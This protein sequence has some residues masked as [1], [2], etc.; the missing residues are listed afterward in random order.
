MQP[1][2][3]FEGVGGERMRQAGFTIVQDTTGWATLG[4]FTALKNV[5]RLWR[6]MQ[7]L[8]RRVVADPPDGIV[9]LDFGAFHVR[10]ALALRQAGYTGPLLYGFPPSAWLDRPKVARCV[11]ELS[12]PLVAFGHQRDFYASLGLP[13]R[14]FGHPLASTILPRLPHERSAHGRFV[15]LPG[16]REQEICQHLPRMLAAIAL[17]KEQLPQAECVV[18]A[19][20][21]RLERVFR[22]RLPAGVAVERDARTWL[23]WADVACVASGTAVL[24]AALLE[25]PTVAIYALSRLNAWIARRMYRGKYVTLPNLVLDQAVVP[26]LLQDAATPQAIAEQLLGLREDPQAQLQGLHA[27]RSALGGRGALRA[28]AEYAL[29]LFAPTGA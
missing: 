11:A 20:D 26:E 4:P 22:E 29:Q 13:V 28:W 10:F 3:S 21:S 5:P 9:L 1:G 24:E 18:V 7:R 6:V 27:L 17:L 14:Y 8:V 23:A 19:A 16:S 2:L 25:V 12:V 15:F